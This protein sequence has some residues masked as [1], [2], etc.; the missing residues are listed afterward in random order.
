M[1]LNLLVETTDTPT[2]T[3][4]QTEAI[5]PLATLM[6]SHMLKVNLLSSSLRCQCTTVD[7]LQ[8]EAMGVLDHNSHSKLAMSFHRTMLD[9]LRNLCKVLFLVSH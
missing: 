2:I 6:V 8:L 3:V 1:F 7:P 5:K 9:L 4:G